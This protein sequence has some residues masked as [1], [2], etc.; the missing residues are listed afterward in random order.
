MS[1]R[2]FRCEWFDAISVSR[3]RFFPK[4]EYEEQREEEEEEEEEEDAIRAS[5]KTRRAKAT[6]AFPLI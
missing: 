6:F 1:S 3:V 2:Y 4:D 5:K